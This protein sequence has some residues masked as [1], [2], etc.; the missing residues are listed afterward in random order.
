MPKSFPLPCEAPETEEK[1]KTFV[2]CSA[3]ICRIQRELGICRTNA[4]LLSPQKTMTKAL[5]IGLEVNDL[6][7]EIIKPLLIQSNGVNMVI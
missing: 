7:E 5:S 4:Q 3:P 1:L 6:T 2:A